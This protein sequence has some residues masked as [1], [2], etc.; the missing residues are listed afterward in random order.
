[1]TPTI[2]TARDVDGVPLPLS[3]E[4]F[5]VTGGLPRD[6]CV[7]YAVSLRRAAESSA[8]HNGAVLRYADAVVST[9]GARPP[10]LDHG[11]AL[12][13]GGTSSSSRKALIRSARALFS[14]SS[15]PP[16]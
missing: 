15:W 16:E 1:M 4:G 14:A 11:P 8:A 10:S 5:F 6:A 3:S 12:R 7:E 2:P 9:P 13:A